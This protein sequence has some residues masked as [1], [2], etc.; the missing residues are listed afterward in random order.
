MSQYAVVTMRA[1]PGYSG[2]VLAEEML[3]RQDVGVPL[4]GTLVPRTETGVYER[5]ID[6]ARR[7]CEA[8]GYAFELIDPADVR[9]AVTV[10]KGKWRHRVERFIRVV[11]LEPRRV[12][13]AAVS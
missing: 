13:G 4:V 10:P 7:S 9:V 8:A 3:R 1:K 2:D 12:V 5:V 6:D 11:K